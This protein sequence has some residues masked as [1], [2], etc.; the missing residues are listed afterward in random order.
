MSVT[1]TD[2][3]ALEAFQAAGNRTGYYDYLAG[4]GDR[5]GTL[6]GDVV[7]GDSVHVLRRVGLDARSLA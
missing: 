3:A 7:Q 4:N 6:A 2:I 5:Y 1:V